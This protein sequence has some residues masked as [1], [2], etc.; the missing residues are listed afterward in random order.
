ML[1]TFV[2]QERFQGTFSNFKARLGRKLYNKIFHILV[3]IFSKLE[4]ITFNVIAHDGTLFSTRARY[5]ECT[6]GFLINAH[7]LL[8]TTLFPR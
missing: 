3:G 1:E 4:M 8:S 7:V 6:P 2:E 5:K